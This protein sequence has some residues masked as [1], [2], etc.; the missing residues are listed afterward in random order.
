MAGSPTY[1]ADTSLD[2]TSGSNL[3]L[4]VQLVFS[5]ANAVTGFGTR[6]NDE[7][8]IGDSVSFINDAGNT[9]TH[10]VELLQIIIH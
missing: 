4:T 7:L 1:T 3:L 5:S 2:T 10:I 9:E 8:K 6:F